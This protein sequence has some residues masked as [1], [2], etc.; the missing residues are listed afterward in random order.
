M[1]EG[2][3]K[4]VRFLLFGFNLIF[5]LAAIG[6]IAI[7]AYVQIALKDYFDLI[8]GKFSTAAALLIAV[9]VI[10]FFIASFGCFGAYRQNRVCVLIFSALLIFIF[11]LEISAGIAGYV[12][13]SQVESYVEKYMKESIG[14]NN[15]KAWETVQKE[16]KCCGI[17]NSTDWNGNIPQSCCKSPATGCQNNTANLYP[18]G[19][20]KKFS[21]WVEDHVA[22]VGGVGIGFAFIQ[23]I[24]IMF[25][26]CLARAIKKEYE[27]V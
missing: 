25:A 7:G 27:V 17:T 3:M 26:C 22:I 12:Y 16:F 5:V 21:D 15:T 9:G 8:G 24:G 2:G 4:C 11:I 1:V 10:I 18:Q 19:C 14:K 23:L 13:K 20:L 6:L